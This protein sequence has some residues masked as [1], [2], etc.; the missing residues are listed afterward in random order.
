MAY[1][2]KG[3]IQPRKKPKK[4]AK[5]G[6]VTTGARGGRAIGAGLSKRVGKGTAGKA[7]RLVG[8]KKKRKP[9]MARIA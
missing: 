8:K 6:V 2:P 3:R 1:G 7:G 5:A 9:K 4:V